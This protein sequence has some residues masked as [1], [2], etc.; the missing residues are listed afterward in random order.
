[1]NTITLFNNLIANYG[2]FPEIAFSG[3][4]YGLFVFRTPEDRMLFCFH[5]LLITSNSIM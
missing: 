3:I 1:M 5:M 2:S 4:F